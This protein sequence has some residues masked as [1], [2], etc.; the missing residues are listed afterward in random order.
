MKRFLIIV[1]AVALV[2]AIGGMAKAN[3]R[4]GYCFDGRRCDR[5]REDSR[6]LDPLR[7]DFYR[8]D[9]RRLDRWWFDFDRDEFRRLDPWRFE[10]YRDDLRY[11]D[12]WKVC[13][14]AWPCSDPRQHRPVSV[15][16]TDV[17]RVE[18]LGQTIGTL[19]AWGNHATRRV[20]INDRG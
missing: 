7:F 12:P 1:M 3:D 18:Q 5:D 4:N 15:S 6:R 2:L 19:P 16:E 9:F 20:P 8:N 10:F 11:F 17:R 14:F 13:L